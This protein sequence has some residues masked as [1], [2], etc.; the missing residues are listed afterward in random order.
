M[1]AVVP[2]LGPALTGTLIDNAAAF[3]PRLKDCAVAEVTT[4]IRALA[5]DGL[6][7]LGQSAEMP[8]LYYSLSHS[9]AGYL[10][11]PVIAREFARFIV[12][13]TAACPLTGKYLAR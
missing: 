7:H 11:A 1:N 5:P 10:R 6:I 8:G 4:G 12:D 3:V 2:A 13:N 9:G